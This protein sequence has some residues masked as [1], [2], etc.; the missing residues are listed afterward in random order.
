MQKH[1]TVASYIDSLAYGKDEVMLLRSIILET[2]LDEG[3]RWGTPTYFYKGKMVVSISVFKSYFGLW[4][5]K[6]V[7]MADPLHV[8]MAGKENQTQTMRQWRFQNINEVHS[9]SIKSYILEAIAVEEKGLK[10]PK[11]PP[12]QIEIPSILEKSVH[13]NSELGL[14]W[15]KLSMSCKR[16]YAEYISSAKKEETQQSRM[17]KIIPMIL[18]AKGLNDKYKSKG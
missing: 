7:L 12:K 5:H 2:G 18:S 11:I 6:G 16:E 15:D 14:A 8:L 9:E 1:L 13:Q 17:Q 4:F 3:I 10:I